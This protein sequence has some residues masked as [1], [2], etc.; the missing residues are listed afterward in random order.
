MRK[1]KTE[2]RKPKTHPR[3]LLLVL[4]A[5]A[6]CGAGCST[7]RNAAVRTAGDM[8]AGEEAL[9]VFTSDDDPEL[10]RD[11]LPFALK[12]LDL[13]LAQDPGNDELR[14][15]TA[16]LYIQYAYA[17]LDSEADYLEEDEPERA[18]ALRERA[19]TLY[20]R[21]RDYAMTVLD[22]AHPAFSK[23]VFS[24]PDQALASMKIQDVPALYWTGA[25]WAAA[26]G[27]NPANMS[28]VAELPIVEPIMRKVLALDPDYDSG[29]VHEFFIN[30][31]GGRGEMMGGNAELAVGHFEEAVR[32]SG[33]QRASPYIGLASTVAVSNQDS[34]MFVTL[35]NQALAV[36]VSDRPGER[37]P[38][39]LSQRKARW[40]LDHGPDLFLEFGEDDLE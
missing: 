13:L 28:L 40:L 9:A 3:R 16:G 7:I 17:F 21:G 35:L 37:L 30:F 26:I 4:I 8:F 15:A 32:L 11:A 29:S 23:T 25:S 19:G 39:I 14:L 18:R 33:G 6:T 31:E 2:N 27:A 20:L 5:V 1:P 34:D 10:I 38:N 12:T 36:D 24:N 22:H